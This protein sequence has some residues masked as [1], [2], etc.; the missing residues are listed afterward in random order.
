[1]DLPNPGCGPLS[2]WALLQMAQNDIISATHGYTPQKEESLHGLEWHVLPWI[3][4]F[5]STQHLPYTHT[6]VVV[7]VPIGTV[8]HCC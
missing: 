5:S 8:P 1:M 7:C 2:I 4:L 3:F 6:I